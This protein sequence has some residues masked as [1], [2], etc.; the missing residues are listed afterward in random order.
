MIFLFYYK[1][2]FVAFCHMSLQRG[3]RLT[4][5]NRDVTQTTRP[6]RRHSSLAIALAAGQ[7]STIPATSLRQG[8]E[9]HF[10]RLVHVELSPI[11]YAASFD[12]HFFR[13]QFCSL[14]SYI[15]ILSLRH[16]HRRPW[17]YNRDVTHMI[18]LAD[19]CSGHVTARR[20]RKYLSP[21]LIHHP[22]AL[23]VELPLHFYFNLE[24]WI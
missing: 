23:D 3:H 21:S 17:A 16:A 14:L 8:K 20:W 24:Y 18:R 10:A 6:A 9:R 12:S 13:A 1:S 15:F 7:L 22:A 2:G 4:P 5:L 19:R 11:C